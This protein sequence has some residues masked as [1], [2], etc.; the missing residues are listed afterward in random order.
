MTHPLVWI[1]GL[2]AGL[3]AVAFTK[4]AG[5]QVDPGSPAFRPCDGPA[6]SSFP[7]VPAGFGAHRG[8]VSSTAS[9][10]ARLALSGT[11]GDFTT[12]VDDDGETRGILVTWHCHNPGEGKPVGWHKGATLMDKVT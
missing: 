5:A 11:L 10:K 12:F 1:A 4:K 7:P 9:A 3:L 2:A 6:P 8:P